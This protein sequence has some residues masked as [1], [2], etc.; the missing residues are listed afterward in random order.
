MTAD[1]AKQVL[2]KGRLV[3]A[4][5]YI[6]DDDEIA[7]SLTLMEARDLTINRDSIQ[8]IFFNYDA[9]WETKHDK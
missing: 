8:R 3:A 1:E 6:N 2:K 5:A 7:V 4:W 9:D